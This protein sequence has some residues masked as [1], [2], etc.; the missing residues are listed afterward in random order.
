MAMVQVTRHIAI[1]EDVLDQYIVCPRCNG[2]PW[3][4]VMTY[5][6]PWTT[7]GYHCN[8]CDCNSGVIRAPIRKQKPDR[9]DESTNAT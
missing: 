2:E 3:R 1:R 6:D 5:S 8:A 7:F 9:T 4:F